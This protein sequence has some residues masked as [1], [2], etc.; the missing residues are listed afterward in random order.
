MTRITRI[1]AGAA[2]ALTLVGGGAV[3]AGCGSDS[4]AT[5]AESTATT[6]DNTVTTPKSVDV[7]VGNSVTINFPNNPSTGYMWKTAG[8]SA[9]DDGLV[10]NTGGSIEEG[11]APVQ[12]TGTT[13]SPAVGVPGKQTYTYK[14]LK[15]GTGEL[16]FE[17]FPPGADTTATETRTVTVTVTG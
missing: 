4:T 5:T 16:K 15:A 9:I 7:A 1:T 12:T 13:T 6:A 2:C 8:G 14:G 3:L 17:L 11:D 10:E